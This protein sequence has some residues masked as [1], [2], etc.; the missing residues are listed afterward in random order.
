MDIGC[1]CL[2]GMN[3]SAV[4]VNADMFLITEVPDIALFT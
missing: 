2:H 3:K 4:L 1:C